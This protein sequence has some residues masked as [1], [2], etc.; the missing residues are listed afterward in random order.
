MSELAFD[1]NG[2]PIQFPADAEELR[3]R[4]FRNPGMR[5][6]C[7]VV[8]DRD[9][10]PLYV[11]VDSSYVELR[12]MVDNAPGRYRLDPVDAARRVIANALPAY[13]TISEAPRN[14]NAANQNDERECVIR[15][16]A[17][18]NADMCKTM[19]EKF[20]S[21]MEAAAGLLRAADGAGLPRRE[22]PPP[23][24]APVP[25]E[26]EEDDEDDED[27]LEDDEAEKPPEIASM[28]AQLMPMLQMWIAAKT[29]EAR[30][31]AAAPV[32]APIPAPAPAPAAAPVT[33]VG[34]AGAAA[35]APAEQA[36]AAPAASV[37]LGRIGAEEP[38]RNAGPPTA[39]QQVHL[40]AIYNWLKPN[41]KKIAE[42]AVRRM[43]P[44]VRNQWLAELS[45][46]TVSE[47]VTLVRSLIAEGRPQKGGES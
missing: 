41:E 12:R 3:V 33:A 46:M 29:A 4:R 17:R 42:L 25:V 19:A 2:E 37:P 45:D 21:V 20:A 32:T 44:E 28:I 9:G 11:P 23:P 27:D 24:P 18:A 36:T 16:L 40:L 7:E 47:A 10:A 43:T 26:E 34:E 1:A 31:P 15:E 8:H 13:I 35:P 39:A 38:A 6:A 14:A 5:G 22:P 30:Q